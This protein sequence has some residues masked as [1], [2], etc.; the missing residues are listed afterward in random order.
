MRKILF[1]CM[2]AL[3]CCS[4]GA[5]QAAGWLRGRGAAETGR[6]EQQHRWNPSLRKGA[7]APKTYAEAWADQ[8]ARPNILDKLNT[9][10]S[11]QHIADPKAM[12]VNKFVA[13]EFIKKHEGDY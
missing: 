7:A 3:C 8:W 9:I 13:L 5:K 4:V 12:G 11:D 1:L 6:A 2:T 10:K